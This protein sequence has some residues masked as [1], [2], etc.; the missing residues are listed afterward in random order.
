ME[1]VHRIT[2]KA[3]SVRLQYSREFIFLKE[4]YQC[5][6][7]TH[8]KSKYESPETC[9]LLKGYLKITLRSF[10]MGEDEEVSQYFIPRCA[11]GVA[12]C[13]DCGRFVRQTI[14][15]Q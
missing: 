8:W 4:S 10:K 5:R 3:E 13:A 1:I 12:C 2:I 9:K 11:E 7:T 6:P 15:D 14:D